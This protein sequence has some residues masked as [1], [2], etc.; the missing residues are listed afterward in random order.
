M[1]LTNKDLVVKKSQIKNAGKGLYTKKFIPKGTVITEYK[2]KITTWKE[3]QQTKTF[4][5]YV[6][7]S[8]TIM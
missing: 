4:N 8:A 7:S 6:F 2:G 5:G 3:A 1:A